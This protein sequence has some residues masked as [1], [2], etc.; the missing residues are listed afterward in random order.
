MKIRKFLI[1][2]MFV[3]IVLALILTVIAPL[4]SY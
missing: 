3:A 1:I 4:L 2:V